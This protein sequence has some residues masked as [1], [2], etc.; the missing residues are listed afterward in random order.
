MTG[1]PAVRTWLAGPEEATTVAA[2]LGE[3]RN[4]IGRSEPS[5]ASFLAG[6]RRL[7]DDPETEYLLGAVGGGEAAGV[8]QL[9]FRF[10]LWQEAGDCWLEDLFVRQAARSTGLGRALVDGAIE[11][12]RVRG[13][14]RVQLDTDSDNAAALALYGRFGFSAQ[15]PSGATRLMMRLPLPPNS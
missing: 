15:T 14:R 3:F 1:G 12:A 8:C 6:I 5:D 9:R 2:L 13:C 4:W 11:R 7:L 10:G